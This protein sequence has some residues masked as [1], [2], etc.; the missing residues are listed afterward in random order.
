MAQFIAFAPNTEVVGHGI[1]VLV[2]GL[3]AFSPMAVAILAEQGI[4]NV[5]ADGW[6]PLQPYLDAYRQI[7]EKV[8]PTTLKLIGKKVPEVVLW[9]PQINS[10]EAALNSI[11]IAYHMNNRGGEIGSYKFTKT[12]ERTGKMVCHNP[13][14]CPFDIG[15]IEATAKKFA[16]ARGRVKVTHDD[17]QGCRS[18]GGETCTLLISW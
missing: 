5:Q 17:T 15:L 9:P 16:P 7:A 4:S 2:E 6:Y 8:G 1:L 14:P 10:V 12:G 13:Y 18:K 3:G 11:D